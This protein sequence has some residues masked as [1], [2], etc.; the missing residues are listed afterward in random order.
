MKKSVEVVGI[1]KGTSKKG[2]S[3][4]ILYLID[5]DE[6]LASN[7]SGRRVYQSFVSADNSNLVGDMVNVYI[8][9]NECIVLDD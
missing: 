6:S 9:R 3:F 2:N 7:F 4:K 1:F 5:V 8:H